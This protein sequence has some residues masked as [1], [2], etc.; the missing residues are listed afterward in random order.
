M[1]GTPAGDAG[2]AVAAVK[3]RTGAD[4]SA[5]VAG[6]DVDVGPGYG[7][8]APGT[9]DTAGTAPARA[10]CDTPAGVGVAE[11]EA[12]AE[13]AAA[14][15]TQGIVPGIEKA[16]CAAAASE[17]EDSFAAAAGAETGTRPPNRPRHH[18]CMFLT[19]VSF[20]TGRTD[21]AVSAAVGVPQVSKP[22]WSCPP[23]PTSHLP[24]GPVMER[25]V[26][27][28]AAVA[29]VVEEE[30]A[31]C[32]KMIQSHRS[33]LVSSRR[34]SAYGLRRLQARRPRFLLV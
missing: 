20:L 26:V 33:W 18:H 21:S 2:V 17:S 9:D 5:I 10:E 8:G 13:A 16:P 7:R 6:D 3:A 19:D 32:V 31:R 30:P 27:D 24:L 12:G 11:E 14:A 15:R 28:I 29:A 1:C 25:H 23:T 34:R 22:T 4:D